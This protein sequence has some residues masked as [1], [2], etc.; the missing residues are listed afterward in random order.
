VD[1]IDRVVFKIAQCLFFKDHGRF[2]PREN[3]VYIKFLEDPITVPT[4]FRDLIQTAHESVDSRFFFYWNIEIEG[5]H[6]YA[7][8]FWGAFVFGIAFRDP[9]IPAEGFEMIDLTT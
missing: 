9:D 8:A 2:L 1:R 6:Y 3:C 4:F 5:C 7:M